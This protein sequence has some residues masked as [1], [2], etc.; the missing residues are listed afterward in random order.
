MF[1]SK[2]RLNFIFNLIYILNVCICQM[3]M[4]KYLIAQ[5]HV[6]TFIHYYAK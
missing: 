1:F 6:V 5:F 3:C 4:S 2:I